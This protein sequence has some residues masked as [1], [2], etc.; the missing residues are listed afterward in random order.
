MQV[1]DAAAPRSKDTIT[2]EITRSQ[3]AMLAKKVATIVNQGSNSDSMNTMTF[4]T[5]L[6][7][8]RCDSWFYKNNLN[9]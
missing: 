7:D 5:L 8:Q 4:S 2:V 6:P 9:G 1:S 3:V